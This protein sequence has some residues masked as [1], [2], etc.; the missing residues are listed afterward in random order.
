VARNS[1]LANLAAVLILGVAHLA[2]AA[3]PPPRLAFS[4]E[5]N[6]HILLPIT[7]NGVA[8]EAVLDSGAG[9]TVLDRS[10]ADAKGIH[11]FGRSKGQGLSGQIEA[12][13]ATADLKV[14]DQVMAARHVWVMDLSAVGKAMHRPVQMI[15]GRD[16]FEQGVVDIDFRDHSL[17]FAPP[18]GFRPPP[19]ASSLTITR[20]HGL[21]TIPVMVGA[22]QAVQA[23]FDLGN[24]NA[25]ILTDKFADSEGLLR[26][27]PVS[28][29]VSYG[30]DGAVATHLATIDS[31]SLAGVTFH[32]VPAVVA[33][34][35]NA[36]APVNVGTEILSR[37]HL[38]VDFQKAQ[39]WLQPYPDA[40]EV[41][42]RKN[43]AGLV[44]LVEGDRWKVV[45]VATG[46][47]GAAGG[48][49]VGDLVT[50]VD[51]HPV[52]ADFESSGL[53]RWMNAPAGRT[54][55]LSL[56]DGSKRRL[57]LADYY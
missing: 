55:E 33:P 42:F 34:R 27:R 14:G 15:L 31:F 36:E 4:V 25:L 53:S 21:P 28:T 43:R 29:G 56:A 38:F 2:C 47:P 10:F 54:V 3:E 57:T 26:N 8:I 23:T 46:G 17:A 11:S 20:S 49:Q 41:A 45:H 9:V 22:G 16:A 6:G 32:S 48:W 30:A 7:I 18:A 52:G 50:A 5:P 40:A 35:P 24:G 12:S 39:L 19:G 13:R 1:I 44:G 37:F 51:G